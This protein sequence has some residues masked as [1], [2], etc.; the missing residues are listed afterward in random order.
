MIGLLPNGLSVAGKEY[1]ICAD[2][3]TALLIFEAF[4]DPEL[5][6]SDKMKIMLDSLYMEPESI[7]GEHLSEA[8][9][10]A[11]W[12][13][14]GGEDYKESREERKSQILSW[15]QDEKMIF[16]GVN[17]AAGYEVR[18]VDFLHWWTFLGYFAEMGECL[19]TTVKSIRQKRADHKRLDKWELDFY[20]KNRDLINIKKTYSATEQAER[21]EINKWLG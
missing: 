19:F 11:S 20:K 12:F 4:D 13:L 16:S 9:E 5:S 14:D 10:K 2:Y 18:A 3:R 15:T 7:P 6:D 1:E 8:L 21:D 17:K